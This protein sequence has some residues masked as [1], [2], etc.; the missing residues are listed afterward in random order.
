MASAA[1]IAFIAISEYRYKFKKPLVL[2][3]RARR[4]FFL[5]LVVSAASLLGALWGHLGLILAIHSWP[6]TLVLANAL[7][8]PLQRSINEAFI[9]SAKE[10]L[11]RMDPVRIGITGSFGKTTTKYFLADILESI[12]PVFVSRGSVNTKLGLTRH[13]RERLQWSHRF[14]IA[15]M[16]AYGV[17]SIKSLCRFVEP[18]FGI[19]TAIGDAH[20]E[21][22]GSVENI[23]KAKAE[24]P[25][26]ICA[27]GGVVVASAEVLKYEP[28]R[29]LK[30]RYPEKF[31]TVGEDEVSD[32]KIEEAH[33]S[34]LVWQIRLRSD[35]GGAPFNIEFE[36]P[37]LG[38][39][40]IF[41]S[42]LAVTLSAVINTES[43]DRVPF[44]TRDFEQIPH[45]LQR[46]ETEGQSL[47]LD[48]SFN[49]NES[50]FRNAVSILVELARSRGGKAIL[51]TPGIAEL[52]VEHARVHSR[53]GEYC[54]KNCDLVLVINPERIPSF[55]EELNSSNAAWE[56]FETLS[57][58]RDKLARI[59][60]PED[61]I[62][63]ENDLPDLLEV[64]R[65]L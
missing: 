34:G 8:G 62:L 32:V 27:R 33:L 31:L 64:K 43:L 65:L 12:D 1:S 42:A 63:Y 44:V 22:F 11:Q 39:H 3:E 46:R 19:V 40:N 25:D 16:G 54:A 24:L 45:R 56:G 5:S 28:F 38:K 61:V 50:G 18:S 7:L 2:T 21:R 48:D 37:V 49:S 14:F 52:G 30:A 47:I 59:S 13:I 4:I 15:E 20:I 23:A 9:R 36:N 51:V 17:G 26:Y 29:A 53:L 6:V 35:V 60:A 10:K 55:V 57:R 58:A 41:N